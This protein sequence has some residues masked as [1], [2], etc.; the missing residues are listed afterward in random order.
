MVEG[1]GKSRFDVS[2]GVANN[3]VILKIHSNES[4]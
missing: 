4:E 3:A 1:K 2:F